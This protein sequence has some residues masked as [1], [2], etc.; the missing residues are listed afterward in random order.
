M[1][2]KIYVK[3]KDGVLDPQGKTVGNSLRTLG[4]GE[5]GEVR[6]G[7]Y[8]EVELDDKLNPV[9]AEKRVDE[10]CSRL[11]ANTI[12]ENYTFEILKS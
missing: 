10:M 5:V 6:I 12:I 8:M 1:L 11:L 7:K 9:E 3:M 4:Y 2:A